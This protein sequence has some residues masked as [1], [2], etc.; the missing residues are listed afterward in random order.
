MDRFQDKVAVITGA[1]S[2]FGREFARDGAANGMKLVLADIDEAALDQTA[3]ALRAQGASVV[4]RRVD[5]S[6]A[7]EMQAL[8]ELTQAEFGPANLLF[9]NAG[10]A[11]SGLCWEG[12]ETDWQWV[13]GVNLYGVVHGLNAF[14]PQ[15]LEAAQADPA[16][17]GHVVNT[18]SM[19][20]L[21]AAPTLGI[22]TASKHAVMG[23]S[24]TLWQ[25]LNLLT[26][27][28]RCSVLCP[29]FVATGIN[30][31]QRVRPADLPPSVPR[32]PSAGLLDKGMTQSTLDAAEVSRMTYQAVREG[33]FYVFTHP[34]M[35]ENTR[36]RFERMLAGQDP[37]PVYADQPEMRAALLASMKGAG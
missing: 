25:E 36:P 7:G 1:G 23:L 27:Q 3:Q 21:T 33:R 6:K 28:V 12:S 24:Q 13:M 9:N 34:D 18:A 10:V 20:S 16:Y 2:G 29:W 31:S 30:D 5:V 15:M 35:L 37:A 19:A 11:L 14:V 32:R 8:A 4:T 26:T 17:Q 22:Y